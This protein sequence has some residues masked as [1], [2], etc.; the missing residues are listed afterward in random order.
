MLDDQKM[1]NNQASVPLTPSAQ[2]P[3]APNSSPVTSETA[4][5][6]PAFNQP[7]PTPST[8]LSAERVEIG[9]SQAAASGNSE[10]QSRTPFRG[11]WKLFADAWHNYWPHFWTFVKLNLLTVVIMLIPFLAVMLAIPLGFSGGGGLAIVG[12]ILGVIILAFVIIFML[13][14]ITA[15]IVL[16]CRIAA[17]KEKIGAWDLLKIAKHNVGKII[18]VAILAGLAVIAGQLL[19]IIPGLIFLTWFSLAAFAVVFEDLGIIKSMGRSYN[20]IRGYGW[21]TFYLMAG[22]TLL[23]GLLG[24]LVQLIGGAGLILGLIFGTALGGE[25]AGLITGLGTAILAA[26]VFAGLVSLL[27]PI[28]EIMPAMRYLDLKNIK[29]NNLPKT[30]STAKA[31]IISIIL[32]LIWAPLIGWGMWA[33]YQE[34]TGKKNKGQP[35]DSIL[36]EIPEIKPSMENTEETKSQEEKFFD[37]QRNYIG[38]EKTEGEKA[39]INDGRHKNDLMAIKFALERYHD[40]KGVYPITQEASHASVL[41]SELENFLLPEYF[42]GPYLY[43]SS[44]DGHKFTLFTKLENLNSSDIKTSGPAPDIPLPEGHNYWITS[45]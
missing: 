22:I 27:A 31:V 4:S 20:L 28:W 14:L 29:D 39:M 1:E 3:S 33:N 43:L 24:L 35:L 26:L 17:G 25:T 41:S 38:P 32:A 2:A 34:L 11:F 16:A 6:E 21:E 19:L 15:N 23:T 18:G 30:E 36:K 40:Q 44:P 13:R 45:D 7:H 5:A 9:Q 42:T 37:E 10:I 8:K 12:I